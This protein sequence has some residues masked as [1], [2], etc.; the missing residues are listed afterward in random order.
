MAPC[1]KFLHFITFVNSEHFCKL[2]PH[3]IS[4]DIIDKTINLGDIDGHFMKTDL[5]FRAR[6]FDISFI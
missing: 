5:W 2:Y 1:K 6:S 3:A 4:D